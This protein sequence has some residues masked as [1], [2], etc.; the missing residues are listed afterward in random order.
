MG[1]LSLIFD[2]LKSNNDIIN[3]NSPAVHHQGLRHPSFN[4]ALHHTSG[5]LNARISSS[6]SMIKDRDPT[7]MFHLEAFFNEHHPSPS[8]T[9]ACTL[10]IQF[11]QSIPQGRT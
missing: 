6:V 5:V 1:T 2:R 11:R 3:R 10:S 4:L 8:S 9:G 7:T